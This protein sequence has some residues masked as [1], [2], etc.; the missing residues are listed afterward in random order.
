VIRKGEGDLPFSYLP[1]TIGRK[2]QVLG[3]NSKT[4]IP[5]FKEED[6]S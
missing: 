1:F 2:L 6:E 5:N 4:E 3:T